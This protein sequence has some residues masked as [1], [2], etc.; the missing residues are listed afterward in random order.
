MKIRQL[1]LAADL[2]WIVL[3]FGLAQIL[4]NGL[5]P[6]PEAQPASFYT[7]AVVAA[8]FLWTVLY[9]SKD[10]E[11]FSRGWYLPS[12]FAQVIV[13]VFYVLGL[14][15]VV[16]FLS[17]HYYSRLTLFYLGCLL[18]VGFTAIRCFAY[19][20]V[21]SQGQVR[22]RRR[23]LIV[24]TGRIVRELMFKIA[25]HPELCMEVAGVL[26]PANAEP[27]NDFSPSSGAVSLRSLNI[28]E[29]IRE[30]NVEEVILV[31][32]L[33]TGPETE[34]LISSCRRAGLRV[35]LVPQQ[36]ELYLSKARITEIEDVPLLSLEEQTLS[37]VGLQGKRAIDFVGAS[38]LLIVSAPLLVA[39]AIVLHRKT[40]RAFKKECR[41]GRN[42]LSFLMYRLN[43]DR[44][45]SNL[46]GFERFLVRFSLSELPQ[47]FNVL[48]GEM[49]LVG[50]RPESPERVKHY[51][52]WQRQ[53]LTVT[54]GL[55]GLAQVNGL[56][57]QHSSEEKAHFDLQYIFH[58]SLFLDVSLVLQT[59]FTLLLRLIEERSLAIA[60]KLKT[61]RDIEMQ[62]P[63]LSLQEVW[64]ANST[65][66]GAD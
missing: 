29:L 31:E 47:L 13:A 41:Y 17:K 61:T 46:A 49:S 19:S 33:P 20:L 21:K 37:S 48:K 30:K 66:S 39:S 45:G 43:V 23:V 59:V 22:A 25:R 16:G 58:W 35:H 42:Q 60:P 44:D 8:A 24:G 10:L 11:G 65:Q 62:A 4:R 28:L 14:V 53:R 5:T 56:R 52:M 32:P 64:N 57:E 1:V 55:T 40:G 51:S 6:G 27:S 12:V 50:P 26:F 3:S 7:F 18:P 63:D 54:P 38:L 2:L 9:F 15:S 34:E 36:Y